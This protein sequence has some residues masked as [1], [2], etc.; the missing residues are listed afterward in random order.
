VRNSSKM[1]YAA[2]AVALI[3]LVASMAGAG[4]AAVKINGNQIKKGTITS[5]QL[6][7]G[8]VKAKDIAPG[9]I[10][11]PAARTFSDATGI[12]VGADPTTFVT[13]GSLT[14]L[15]AGDYSISGKANVEAN[16]IG[17]TDSAQVICALFVNGVEVDR[18][19]VQIG[20]NAADSPV[21]LRAALP[22]QAVAAVPANGT[23]TFGCAK[24]G[25]S[26]DI[27]A[28]RRQLSAI[29]VDLP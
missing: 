18:S 1:G 8:K 22:V 9:V 24:G 4:Y 12:Q 7:N 28:S 14:G 23:V 17:G 15:A 13:V 5:K 16:P 26:I 21:V 19:L 10:A 25:A 6:K 27:H 2:M 11:P 29:S 3:A 20:E